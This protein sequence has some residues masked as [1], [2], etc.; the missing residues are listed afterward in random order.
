MGMPISTRFVVLEF[1]FPIDY[2]VIVG[3]TTHSKNK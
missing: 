3:G 2:D 1:C